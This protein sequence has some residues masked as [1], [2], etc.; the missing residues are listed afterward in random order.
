M[1]R[2]KQ[3]GSGGALPPVGDLRSCAVLLFARYPV[4]GQAK[5]RLIPALGSDG[6]ARLH[7]RMTENA[8]A[9]A[10]SAGS[11]YAV[12]VCF[13]GAGEDEFRSWLG[14]GPEFEAQPEG[15]LG[16]RMRNAFESAFSKGAT[17]AL[18]IGCDVPGITVDL[19]HVADLALTTH[20][21]VL[22]PA[23][24]GGYYLLGVKRLHACLFED[25]EWGTDQ[26]YSQTREAITRHGLAA[27]ELTMLSDV[28]RPGD[29]Q[30]L[31]GDPRFANVFRQTGR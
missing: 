14:P 15:D 22:G 25:I 12:T 4:P 9:V 19:L 1:T 21:V 7:Q 29:L 27:H 11:D 10:R 20:D 18:A 24:D 31:R 6:A 13:T 23:S 2:A 30:A 8:L 28:D 3:A 5:T 17:H 16:L 26:V